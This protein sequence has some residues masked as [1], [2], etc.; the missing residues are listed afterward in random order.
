MHFGRKR[1]KKFFF[2]IIVNGFLF[3]LGN[4]VEFDEIINLGGT[5]QVAYQMYIN[6]LRK[7]ALPFDKVRT[8]YDSLYA[9]MENKFQGFMEPENF[10]LVMNDKEKYILDKKYGIKLFHDFKI[11][12][13]FLND[14]EV[15]KETYLRR[16]DR[17]FTVINNSKHPLFIRRGITKEQAITLRDLLHRL[18][19]SKPFTIITV[20]ST[21]EI[22]ENWGL[23][24]IRNF[25]LRPP[26]P[27]TWKGDNG[28]WQE[29]FKTLGLPIVPTN[30]SP[31]EIFRNIGFSNMQVNES[32]YEI[33]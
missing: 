24:E 23:P 19:P 4:E 20:D 30:E 11:N 31:A 12:D 26:N 16:I 1:I 6:G 8:P 33:E 7:Y 3:I 25:F 9:I 5:C 10:V 2:F 22:K 21:Q 14:F 17:F 13:N 27:A 18:F 15:I 28:A 29:L 32:I